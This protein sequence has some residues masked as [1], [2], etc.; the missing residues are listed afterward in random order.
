MKIVC[1][2]GANRGI[3]LEL[4]RR[5]KENGDHVVALVRES[6][7][8]L[9]TITDDIIS[10]VD[11]TNL[12]SIQAA[13]SQISQTKIDILINN[14]GLLQSET[15]DQ[16]DTHAFERIQKQFDINAMGPLRVTSV[17]LDKLNNPAKC[18]LITSRMGSIAD[19]SSGSRYGYRMSKSA[20]E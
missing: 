2:T 4:A 8:E 12:A 15:I 11:V 1:I 10:S 17:L 5:F 9:N 7:A 14:A 16:L 6:S 18:I 13:K 3:G 20:F 19:N